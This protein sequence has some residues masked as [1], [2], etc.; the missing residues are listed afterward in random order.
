[1][2]MT[3]VRASAATAVLILASMAM[4]QAQ[5][6]ATEVSPEAV[7]EALKIASNEEPCRR[8]RRI[9]DALLASCRSSVSR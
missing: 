2:E 8:P 1:M 6:V 4:A 5:Q 7:E 3:G 9:Y